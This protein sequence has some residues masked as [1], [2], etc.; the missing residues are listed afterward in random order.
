MSNVE[1]LVCRHCDSHHAV[2]SRHWSRHW[3]IHL[4]N[5]QVLR[6]NTSDN[7][8]N[9]PCLKSEPVHAFILDRC[10]MRCCMTWCIWMIQWMLYYIDIYKSCSLSLSIL[11]L[12]WNDAAFVAESIC[13]F[14]IN[15]KHFTLFGIRDKRRIAFD[16]SRMQQVI[17]YIASGTTYCTMS[18][19]EAYSHLNKQ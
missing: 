7:G 4:K 17:S 8:I 12:I 18:E 11:M 2:G 14:S 5:W 15:R 9:W 3:L 1:T 19:S 16:M 13:A 6:V 10:C